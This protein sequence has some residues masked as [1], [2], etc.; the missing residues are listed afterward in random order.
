MFFVLKKMTTR[1]GGTAIIVGLQLTLLKVVFQCINTTSR[2][3]QTTVFSSHLDSFSYNQF[4]SEM[5][6]LLNLL[7]TVAL[8]RTTSA[9]VADNCYNNLNHHSASAFCSTYTTTINT[10]TTGLPTYIPTSCYSRI[11]SVCTCLYPVSTSI[12]SITTTTV[13]I[14]KVSTTS[15]VSDVT[16][17]QVSTT[18]EY[19]GVCPTELYYPKQCFWT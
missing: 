4:P 13:T 3:P 6:A 15:V 8:I 9:C 12:S 18:T 16:V 7:V 17:T 2:P 19:C 11:S 14:T 5:A 1:P 10:A